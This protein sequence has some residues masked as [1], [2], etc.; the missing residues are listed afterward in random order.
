LYSAATWSFKNLEEEERDMLE[1]IAETTPARAYYP[2]NLKCMKTEAWNNLPSLS[3]HGGLYIAVEE[4]LGHSSRFEI[5]RKSCGPTSSSIFTELELVERAAARNSNFRVE[6]F[7]G[8][9]VELGIDKTYDSRDLECL[10]SS[11][12][13]TV[14]AVARNT[15]AWSTSLDVSKNILQQYKVWR[16]LSKFTD[17]PRAIQLG[18]NMEWLD[19]NIDLKT[20]WC[21]LYD[22]CT[23]ATKENRYDL[24]FVLS[25]L[26]YA[27]NKVELPLIWTL[28]AFATVPE[29][30]KS[31][32]PDYVSYNLRN[33]YDAKMNTLKKMIKKSATKFEDSDESRVTAISNES[34]EDRKERG[35]SLYKTNLKNQTANLATNFYRQWICSQPIFPESSSPLIIF[36]KME[37]RIKNLFKHW[38]QNHQL[39][40]HAV[41]IQEYLD[42][43]HTPAESLSEYTF[44]HPF[45]HVPRQDQGARVSLAELLCV[46]DDEN[47]RELIG[48]P[49]EKLLARLEIEGD[50]TGFEG[51]YV[52]ELR[53]SLQELQKLETCPETH[54]VF[55]YKNN[56]HLCKEKLNRTFDSIKE[57]FETPHLSPSTHR[58]LQLAGLWPRISPK[59]L[60]RLLSRPVRDHT[61]R[62]K[63]V[64][65]GLAIARF[66]RAERMYALSLGDNEKELMKEVQN[67]G[68][69]DW[70]PMEQPEWLLLEIE[71]GILI[72]PIQAKIAGR[73]MASDPGVVQLNMGEGKSSGK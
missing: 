4:I 42:A 52:R 9:Y 44:S 69:R 71:S 63:L 3:Q 58:F 17:G 33:G 32:M 68:H 36:D 26:A 40:L 25:E 67:P 16:S 70:D 72:R 28:L 48:A 53:S 41:K 22:A 6:E 51:L 39:R 5:F 8:S 49:L 47:S 13:A 10:G 61:Q 2:E 60:L 18:H 64:E 43:C 45:S 66:Q 37:S 38:Y 29:F 35:L 30:E 55:H 21:S 73:M 31:P 24:M 59:S 19:E 7:G 56:L 65:Y 23:R 20:M 27:N 14:C 12:E 62:E 57:N 54:D 50:T 34:K 15:D 1:R 11:L 46:R